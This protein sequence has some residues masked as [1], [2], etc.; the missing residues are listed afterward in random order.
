MT[1]S[2]YTYTARSEDHPEQVVRFTLRGRRVWI[3]V[4]RRIVGFKARGEARHKR[5]ARGQEKNSRPWLRPAEVLLL[6]GRMRPFRITDV[7]AS[8]EDDSMRIAVWLRALGL[9]L[10]AITIVVEHVEDLEAAEGFVQELQTRV[11]AVEPSG[12]FPHSLDRRAG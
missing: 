11:A 9:R 8:V 5:R 3:R 12:K 6:N 10:A 7:D 2:A 1:E 4:G